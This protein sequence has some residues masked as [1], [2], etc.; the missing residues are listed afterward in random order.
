MSMKMIKQLPNQVHI[1]GG[2]PAG[3]AAAYFAKSKGLNFKL[4]E[5]SSNLGGNCRTLK[6]GDC[7]F[8]TGAHRFHDKDAD[9]TRIIKNLLGD[10]L[11][12]VCAPSQIFYQN[13]FVNF[14][15][16]LAD[17]VKHLDKKILFKV[18]LES[19]SLQPQPQAAKNFADFA[20][21]QYGPTLSKL[22]LLNYTQKLWGANADFLSTGVAGG[23]LKGL[24]LKTFIRES[25]LGPE[26]STKHIDGKFLYPRYGFGMIVDKL[27][28]FVS[29]RHIET[30]CRVT[31]I[32]HRKRKIESIVINNR[33]RIPVH[34]IINTLPLTLTLQILE[35]APPPELIDI[36]KSIQFRHLILLAYCVNRDSISQNASIYFPDPQL[37]FT[38]LYE[39]KNRS[40][41]MAPKTQTAIVLELPCN[42]NDSLWHQTEAKLQNQIW[43]MFQKVFSISSG[44]IQKQ[45]TYKLPFAY[46][47]LTVDVEDKVARLVDYCKQFNNMYL[48]GR[49][50]LFQYLHLHDLFKKGRTVVNQLS[51]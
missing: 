51:D 26:K 38:R 42:Q 9:T 40:Q 34:Q 4:I 28:E 14:P 15:L 5:G 22:F 16:N 44:E 46:P 47:V 33:Q 18:I 29:L 27:T 30:N 39:P 32:Q 12:D 10:D 1:L 8:D 23:R 25:F 13:S 24:D 36:A 2:G 45:K 3:L 37:P 6:L 20:Q 19:L 21:N 17:L 50:A 41:Q 7:L 48:T 31:K 35:P 11:I 49:N 43:Q